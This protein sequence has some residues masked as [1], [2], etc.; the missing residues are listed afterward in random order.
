MVRI[1]VGEMSGE[2]C[3]DVPCIARGRNLDDMC[4]VTLG[5]VRERRRCSRYT[6]P[7]S[8]IAKHT[9]IRRWLRVRGDLRTWPRTR[10]KVH[11]PKTVLTRMCLMHSSPVLR[12]RHTQPRNEPE[13]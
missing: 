4:E 12:C 8:Y 5:G 2:W 3:P 10:G 7:E 13:Y 9:S 6:Y 11:A 1:E